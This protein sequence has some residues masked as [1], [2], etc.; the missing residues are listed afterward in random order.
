MLPRQLGGGQAST[1]AVRLVLPKV[2]AAPSSQG[3]SLL[4]CCSAA[5]AAYPLPCLMLSAAGKAGVVMSWMMGGWE[6]AA[7]WATGPPPE[8]ARSAKQVPPTLQLICMQLQGRQVRAGV[9]S[10]VH[11]NQVASPASSAR[12]WELRN[13]DKPGSP[14]H[15]W[16]EQRRSPAAHRC[17]TISV[18]LAAA[19]RPAESATLKVMLRTPGAAVLMLQPARPAAHVWGR[20]VACHDMHGTAP[21]HVQR[22]ASAPIKEMASAITATTTP[23]QECMQGRT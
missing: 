4:G 14:V 9:H 20:R 19:L 23:A 18:R 15:T 7:G 1:A 10:M 5:Q 22:Q 2:A 12:N 17:C 3:S 6:A 13:C 21:K 8:L 16:S 11:S